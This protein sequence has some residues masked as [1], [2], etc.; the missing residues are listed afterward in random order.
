MVKKTKK[1]TFGLPFIVPLYITIFYYMEKKRNLD[2][3]PNTSFCATE[4]KIILESEWNSFF[5]ALFL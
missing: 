2:I 1:N 3:L 5:D 4:W